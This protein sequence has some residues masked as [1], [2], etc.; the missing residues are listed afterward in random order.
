MYNEFEKI[1]GL[2][3]EEANV[4]IPSDIFIRVASSDG[5]SYPLRSDI[6]HS[7]LTVRLEKELIT[8]V[9]GLG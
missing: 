3:I 7:R 1:I 9:L 4:K 6:N 5:M 8:E 2:S